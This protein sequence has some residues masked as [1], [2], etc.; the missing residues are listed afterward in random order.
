M[1]METSTKIVNITT[2]VKSPV[3]GRDVFGNEV[4]IYL[5][6]Y[7]FPTPGHSADILSKK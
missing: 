4:E 2:K 5:F 1:R 6:S 3:P 7:L